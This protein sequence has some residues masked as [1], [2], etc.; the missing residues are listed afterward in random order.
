MYDILICVT[1]IAP[2]FCSLTV[3]KAVEIS[4]FAQKDT[5][6]LAYAY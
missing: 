2:N 6:L 1:L 4:V 3:L 5:L